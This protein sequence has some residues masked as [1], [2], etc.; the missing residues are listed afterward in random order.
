MHELLKFYLV[1][2]FISGFVFVTGSRFLLHF[3][4]ILSLIGKC[5]PG[6]WHVPST[7][8]DCQW[9]LISS[10]EGRPQRDWG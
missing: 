2:L 9:S 7:L 3:K 6:V 8:C 5:F 4:G 1:K 10:A